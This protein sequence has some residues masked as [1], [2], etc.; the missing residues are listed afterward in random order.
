MIKW[1][2]RKRIERNKEIAKA[3]AAEIGECGSRY[4]FLPPVTLRDAIYL[5][6][7]GGTV[8]KLCQDFSGQEMI[9]KIRD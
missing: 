5:V 8:F 2:R 6:T 9:I 3:V 4:K 7:E 1:F